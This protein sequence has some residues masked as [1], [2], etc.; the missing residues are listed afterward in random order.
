[1]PTRQVDRL[2]RVVDCLELPEQHREVLHLL[3][4]S[5]VRT[6]EVCRLPSSYGLL[7][8]SRANV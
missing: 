5:V 3:I 2:S 4:Y 7:Q 1:M 8:L 6:L